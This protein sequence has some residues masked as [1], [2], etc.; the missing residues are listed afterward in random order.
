MQLLHL[1]VSKEHRGW[2]ETV[3]ANRVQRQRAGLQGRAHSHYGQRADGHAH[4]LQEGGGRVVVLLPPRLMV[5][6]QVSA[7][8]AVVTKQRDHT[9]LVLE[10]LRHRTRIVWP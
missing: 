1:Q 6:C 7:S 2:I 9:S 3:I 10:L 5:V 8:E 4:H